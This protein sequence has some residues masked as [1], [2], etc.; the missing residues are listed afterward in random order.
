MLPGEAGG[1]GPG[2]GWQL[3]GAAE[4]VAPA[5]GRVA[6]GFAGRRLMILD[7]S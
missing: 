3:E 5:V 7:G 2:G 6:G 1:P 4:A